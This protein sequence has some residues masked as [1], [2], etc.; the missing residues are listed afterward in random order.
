MALPNGLR[1]RKEKTY[2][3]IILLV[4]VF[5][6]LFYGIAGIAFLLQRPKLIGIVLFYTVF[7]VLG[8]M[9]VRAF[10]RAYMFGHYV[11]VGPTQFPGLFAAVQNGAQRLGLGSTPRAFVYNGNGLL[12][13]FAVRLFGTPYVLLTASLID[14]ETDAQVNSSWA[15]SWATTRP[16]T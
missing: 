6:W 16:D 12:N 3:I 15:T 1:H 13:A 7:L 14:A 4:S 8:L 11:L 5:V 10:A 2:G 9:L